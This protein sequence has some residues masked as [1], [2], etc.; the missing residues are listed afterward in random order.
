MI[1]SPKLNIL[2]ESQQTLSK[3]LKATSRYLC[4]KAPKV[5]GQPELETLLE[6]EL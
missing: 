4:C 5:V 6:F 2:P 3:E 1:F